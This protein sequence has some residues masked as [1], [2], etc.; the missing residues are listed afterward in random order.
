MSQLTTI[1][2]LVMLLADV[3]ALRKGLV[4]MREAAE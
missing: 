2:V 3:K 1:L 4:Q